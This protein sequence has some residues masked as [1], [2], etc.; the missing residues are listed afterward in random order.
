[1][2]LDIKNLVDI[3]KGC[4]KVPVNGKTYVYYQIGSHKNDNGQNINHRVSLGRLD[5]DSGKLIP[6][7]KYY[8]YFPEAKRSLEPSV[9]L[10]C[11]LHAVIKN[12]VSEL[13][14][15]ETLNNCFGDSS[16]RIL[17][18]AQY[19]VRR[20]SVMYYY[21]DY[22]SDNLTFSSD[23]LRS[24]EISRLFESISEIKRRDFFVRWLHQRKQ[25]E[26]LAYDVTSFS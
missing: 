11:G 16:N 24:A 14:L 20:G 9:I 12:I 6:N 22:V 19:M 3:P 1:M 25:K 8:Y 10:N 17:A 23:V 2:S 26:C 5:S 21:D 7:D 15:D 13:K 18:L 4:H